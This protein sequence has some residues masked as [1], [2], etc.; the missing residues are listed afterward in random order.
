MLSLIVM[1]SYKFGIF[2]ADFTKFVKQFRP[3]E[4]GPFR[5]IP[6]SESLQFRHPGEGRGPETQSG[7]RLPP[8]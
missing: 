2:I 4:V 6:F 5:T 8:E 3:S 1:T 7:F